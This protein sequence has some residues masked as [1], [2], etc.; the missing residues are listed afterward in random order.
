MGFLNLPVYCTGYGGNSQQ[1][2][3]FLLLDVFSISDREER[4]TGLSACKDGDGVKNRNVVSYAQEGI[5]KGGAE[6]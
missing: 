4:E 3:R 2:Y 1:A 6:P 5:E